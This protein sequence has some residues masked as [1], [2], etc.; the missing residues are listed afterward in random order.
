MAQDIKE[1]TELEVL[2][3]FLKRYR[4]PLI[5]VSFICGVL[6]AAISLLIPKEYKSTAV[7]FPPAS[8]SLDLSTENPNFGYDIEAD[9]LVQILQSKEIRDSVIRR[10]NLV[11]YYDINPDSRDWLSKADRAYRGDV[12]FK[13]STF[14]SIVIS[15]QTEDPELSANIVNYILE[16]ANKVRENIYKQN[17]KLAYNKIMDEYKVEKMITDSLYA[18]L[19]KRFSDEGISGL[20][21]LAPNAQ[22]NFDL[23]QMTGK[24]GEANTA[25]LLGAEI[26]K[27]RFHLDLQNEQE[28]RAKHVGKMLEYPVSQIHILDSAEPNYRKTYPMVTLNVL[29]AFVLGF[30]FTSIYFIIKP[31]V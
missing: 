8:L 7:V 20:L 24:K 18:L 21:L 29:V 2:F 15:C 25:S 5:L 27:Y 22:L 17:V 11:E 3:Q 19:Q 26:L 13:R 28:T 6:S 23:Q 9:R 4:M 31:R 14:M 16:M 30:L 12:E 10:F 1:K